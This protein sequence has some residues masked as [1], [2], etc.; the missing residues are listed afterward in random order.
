MKY[1]D[2]NVQLL[3]DLSVTYAKKLYSRFI[4]GLM[5][6]IISDRDEITEAMYMCLTYMRWLDNLADEF[7]GSKE[8]KIKLL[9]ENLKFLRKAQKEEFDKVQLYK[10]YVEQRCAYFFMKDLAHGLLK[11]GA[12][13]H[14][15]DD[16]LESYVLMIESILQDTE[17]QG[18]IIPAKE[19]YNQVYWLKAGVLFRASAYILKN[20]PS[21]NLKTAF[22]YFGYIWQVNNDN[23]D[24]VEDLQCNII[25]ITKEEIEKHNIDLDKWREKDFEGLVEYLATTSFFED[26][27]KLLKKWKI[28]VENNIDELSIGHRIL[29]KQYLKRACP[30]EFKPGATH[31]ETLSHIDNLNNRIMSYFSWIFILLL[32]EQVLLNILKIINYSDALRPNKLFSKVYNKYDKFKEKAKKISIPIPRSPL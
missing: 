10:L 12:P 7:D 17:N 23:L 8:D 4:L 3:H 30:D 25:N 29:V 1:Q 5:S 24:I 6:D 16:V 11:R 9:L 15:V 2:K 26:R 14:C 27:V 31:F 18:R 22:K 20:N 19:F 13:Q 28:I 21:D 32:P